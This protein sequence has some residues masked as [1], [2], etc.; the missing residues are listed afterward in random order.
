MNLDFRSEQA[1]RG[2]REYARAC[3]AVHA[4]RKTVRRTVVKRVFAAA[5]ALAVGAAVALVAAAQAGA[6]PLP[7][8]MLR[9]AHLARHGVAPLPSHVSAGSSLLALLVAGAA[10]IV[11]VTLAATLP[12]V[13]VRSRAHSFPTPLPSRARERSRL[14]A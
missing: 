9:H 4:T 14:A 2:A 10:T 6:K 11:L 8:A 1:I 12:A 7:G 13:V 3:R 5:A